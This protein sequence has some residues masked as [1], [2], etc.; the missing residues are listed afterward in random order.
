[1]A[2]TET[3]KT[4]SSVNINLFGVP[5]ELKEMQ[6]PS[7]ADIMRHY[8]WLRNE[9]RDVYLQ[10]VDDFVKV[11]GEKVAEIWVKAS[12][13]VVSKRT[14]NG[15]LK[16]ITK[17]CKCKDLD[18]CTCDKSRKVPKRE[19][20]FLH[21]QRTVQELCIGNTEKRTS[22]VLIKTA[23]RERKRT[24]CANIFV[25]GP[26]TSDVQSTM[27]LKSSEDSLCDRFEESDWNEVEFER[28]ATP[29]TCKRTSLSR[30]ASA[31]FRTGVSERCGINC[32][33]RAARRRTCHGR[34]ESRRR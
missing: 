30:K 14:V 25:S 33:S 9:N 26:S 20:T 34:K 27:V 28:T 11:V 16:T 10:P 18:L 13:P 19:V 29:D 22:K 12:I 3:H 24:A 31:A 1:M 4:R 5:Y 7:Y 8:Y 15:K 17:T 23:A 32:F 21:D 6:L 2:R